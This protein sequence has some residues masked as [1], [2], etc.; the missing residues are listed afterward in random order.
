MLL[1]AFTILLGLVTAIYLSAN[2]QV[3]K[4]LASPI[5]A[6]IPFFATALLASVILLLIL[7]EAQALKSLSKV[8]PLL[9]MTGVA[10]ALMILGT[11]MLVPRLGS[12]P[13]FVLLLTGQLVGSLVVSH[14]GWLSSPVQ[15]IGWR[16]LAGLAL[17]VAGAFTALAGR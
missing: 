13:F 16:E 14:F 15:P 1:G 5:A 6:S 4:V 8:H 9:L 10:S 12:G 7:G 2:G 17:M 3:G 11:T